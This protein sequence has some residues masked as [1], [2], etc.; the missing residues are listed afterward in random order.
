MSAVTLD[1]TTATRSLPPPRV[2]GTELRKMFDTRS[3]LWLLASIAIASVLAT[4]AVIAF[5]PDKELTYTTFATAIGF[6]MA[7]ILPIIAILSVTSEWSQ[8]NG[9]TTF[10][11]VPSRSR[12]IAAKLVCSV[13]VGVASMA[14]AMAVGALGTVVGSALAGVDQVWDAS[15]A[16]LLLIVLGN[17]LGMLVGF[18]LGVLVRSSAGAIV[19]YFVYSFLLPT[20]SGLL[21]ASQGWFRDL[22]PWVDFNYAQSALFN[23]P[24]SAE[25]WQHLVVT[26][27]LWLLLPT[28][29]GIRL[30]MRSEVK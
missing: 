26:G 6:P 23:G 29:V 28:L 18:M 2:T 15:V 4:A 24:L 14:V 7:V 10:T 9:L 17:V 22:Q 5:A 12:V 19:G 3:G 21:A 11:L 8:R 20:L 25:Q 13:L 16:D 30:V 1:R 27:A